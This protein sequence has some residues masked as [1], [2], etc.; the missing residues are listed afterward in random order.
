MLVV[1]V[2]NTKPRKYCIVPE[3]YVYGL[4]GLEDQLLTWGV[5]PKFNH[6]VYWKRTFL[7]D[8]IVP[9]SQNDAN[10]HLAPR[11]DYPPPPGIDAACYK[12]QIKKFYSEYWRVF[13]EKI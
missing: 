7:D 5:D 13:I 9:V 11:T 4:K 6:L 3:E 1:V 12:A 2:L 8:T 10:F